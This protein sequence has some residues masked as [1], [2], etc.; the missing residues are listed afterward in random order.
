[1]T[2]TITNKNKFCIYSR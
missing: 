2:Q 1:M